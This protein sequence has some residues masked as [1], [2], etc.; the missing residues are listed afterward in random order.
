M[1]WSSEH[2]IVALFSR[3]VSIKPAIEQSLI[4]EMKENLIVLP[5]LWSDDHRESFF[6][7]ATVETLIKSYLF[8]PVEALTKK[9]VADLLTCS[10]LLANCLCITYREISKYRINIIFVNKQVS[11]YLLPSQKNGLMEMSPWFSIDFQYKI[12]HLSP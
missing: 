10:N 11:N 1:F 7:T 3:N 2:V 12:S 6:E 5:S 4:T 9:K 8:W